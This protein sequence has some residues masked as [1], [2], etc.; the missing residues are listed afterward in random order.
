MPKKSSM[1]AVVALTFAL[2]MGACNPNPQPQGLT[3]IP[4]LA[5]AETVTLVP[6]LQPVAAVVGLPAPGMGVSN[7]A[8]GAPTY[9]LHCPV[10]HGVQGEGTDVPPLRNSQFV[11]TAGD[12][13][14]V[15]AIADG[16]PNTEMPAW[17]LS[18][19]GPLTEAQ[20]GELVA[21]LQTLQG[22]A[23]VPPATPMPPEPTEAPP[24]PNAPTPEPA[25][26]SLPGETGPAAL[27]AGDTAQGVGE[28]G[29]Y[30][31]PCHGPQGVEEVGAPNPGSDDGI[32]PE[33]N[34]IDPTI[35]DPDPNIFATNLDLFI[36][37]GSI[38]S[39]PSPL[40]MMPPFGDDKLLTEQ[41]IAD[42]IAYV[43]LL[44]GVE[45]K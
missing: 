44:N 1:T 8:L 45:Q 13:A 41:E 35:V 31:A 20:I 16:R 25:R 40:I 43:M 28:F 18:N 4:T 19:G 30:C 26:P 10:C 27:L 9:M 3:P 11:Q 42:L 33:L 6:A 23:S 32:V 5:A 37:H 21:Y 15:T 2:L 12:A 14:V 39:G 34:P 24:A 36:E 22:V 7:E 17:L 29:L 38:P